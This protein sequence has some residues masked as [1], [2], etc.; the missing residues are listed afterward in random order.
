[1]D[2]APLISDEQ[3]IQKPNLVRL[4]DLLTILPNTLYSIISLPLLIAVDHIVFFHSI[5]WPPL[6]SLHVIQWDDIVYQ[7]CHFFMMLL[8]S[9]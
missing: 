5:V 4:L 8:I 7:F 6:P 9:V 2:N 1:M 3:T